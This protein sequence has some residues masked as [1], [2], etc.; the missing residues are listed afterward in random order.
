M[1]TMQA[2][3]SATLER[4]RADMAEMMHETAS[5]NAD[6]QKQIATA[7]ERMATTRWWQT[8]VTVGAVGVFAAI[9]IAAIGWM[10]Q[11]TL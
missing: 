3:L 11:L 8:A 7:T 9:I 5:T 2:D 10:V 1:N 4:F 6:T